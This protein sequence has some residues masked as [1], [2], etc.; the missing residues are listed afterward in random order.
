MTYTSYHHYSPTMSGGLHAT[1]EG[2]CD[3]SESTVA[4]TQVQT[5]STSP[6]VKPALRPDPSTSRSASGSGKCDTTATNAERDPQRTLLA[7]AASIRPLS[8][9]TTADMDVAS[10]DDPL[11]SPSTKSLTRAAEDRRASNSASAS[12]CTASS[13]LS[14]PAA[15]S[16]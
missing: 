6:S 13:S 2:M 1:E 15:S 8:H 9:S 3:S 14:F 7:V 12:H 10:E 5:A 16:R 4:R 11:T